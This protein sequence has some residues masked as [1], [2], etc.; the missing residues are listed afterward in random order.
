[1]MRVIAKIV[2]IGSLLGM[3]F[4]LFFWAESH[5]AKCEDTTKNWQYTK[6]VEKSVNILATGIARDAKQRQLW[7]LED[8]YNTRDPTKVP[9]PLDRD[10]MRKLQDE[11]PSLD[12]R[13]DQMERD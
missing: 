2:L 6:R 10:N 7:A 13:I 3:A 5:Y 8:R 11:I 9:I 1:M 4:G 12:K